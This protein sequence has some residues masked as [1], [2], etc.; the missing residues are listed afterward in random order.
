MVIERRRSELSFFFMHMSDPQFGMFADLSGMDDARIEE[1]RRER[2]I[3]RP[4]PKITGFANETALYGKAIAEANRL[5]PDFVVVSGDM[6]HRSR[7]PELLAELQRLTA[8]LNKNIPIYWVAGN[9][10]MLD[11]QATPEALEA[12]HKR[13]GD[14]YYSFDHKGCRFIAINSEIAY[15]PSAVPEEW[16]SELAFLDSAM[17]E[18]RTRGNNRIIIFMHHL[19]FADTPDEKDSVLN[20]PLARRRVLLDMF[21]QYRVTAVFTGHWHRNNYASYGGIKMVATAAV[22]YPFGDDPSGL[23]IVK[24]F[25]DRIEHNYYALDAL[26]AKVEM[27]NTA[28]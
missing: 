13:F 25:D 27:A 15:D 22:G 19:L 2:L 28:T 18:A 9:H 6:L 10:D 12:Y 4:S 14:D 7:N 24:V 3:V 26:P 20:I 11:K 21:R 23:R 5:C 1:F 8:S 16:Q 17:R